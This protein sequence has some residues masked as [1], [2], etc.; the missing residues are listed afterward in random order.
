[1]PT[2]CTQP[3]ARGAGGVPW[4]DLPD[5]AHSLQAERAGILASLTLCEIFHHHQARRWAGLHADLCQ[6]HL[7]AAMQF[8]ALRADVAGAMR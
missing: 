1:M 5:M 6:G 4:Q 3:M 2:T 8:A 7:K